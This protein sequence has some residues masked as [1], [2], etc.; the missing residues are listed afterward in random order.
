MARAIPYTGIYNH[1]PA[2]TANVTA[3]LTKGYS[4]DHW[5]LDGTNI[6]STN[7]TSIF[8]DNNHTLHA[9]FVDN[10]PQQIYNPTQDP[11]DDVQPDQNV[12]VAAAVTDAGSGVNNVTLWYSTD[13]GTKWT[14]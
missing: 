3:V 5:E 11:A 7:P 9:V 6:G 2:T 14:P 1:V 12:T 8:M 10:T 13:N 4:S